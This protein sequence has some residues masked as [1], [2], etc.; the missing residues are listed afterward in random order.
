MKLPHFEPYFSYFSISLLFSGFFFKIQ[1]PWFLIKRVIFTSSSVNSRSS[2]IHVILA[3]S[4]EMS[5]GLK[6]TK[7]WK[8]VIHGIH[9]S[10]S[11]EKQIT[12]TLDSPNV[13]SQRISNIHYLGYVYKNHSTYS[14]W[15][16]FQPWMICY[17]SQ[18]G[19][20]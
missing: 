12:F 10:L 14:I 7:M 15:S 4:N 11:G 19:L 6:I 18:S 16:M 3:I 8:F 5:F 20:K 13:W 9:L 2:P 1:R 17:F